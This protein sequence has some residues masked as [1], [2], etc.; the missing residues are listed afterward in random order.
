MND[1]K[2]KCGP[3]KLWIMITTQMHC[4]WISLVLRPLSKVKPKAQQQKKDGEIDEKF[5]E[6][7]MSAEKKDYE[8][9]CA[10][11]GVTNFRW[12][13]NTLNVKK[14]EREEEQALVSLYVL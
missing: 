2:Q 10:E 6:I 12:M 8:R 13:L 11:Y 14:Q 9:I 7:L 1:L 5:W 3:V 4:W